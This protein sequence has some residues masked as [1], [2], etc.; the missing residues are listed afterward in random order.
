MNKWEKYS[1]LSIDRPNKINRVPSLHNIEPIIDKLHHQFAKIGKIDAI[2]TKNGHIIHYHTPTYQPGKNLYWDAIYQNAIFQLLGNYTNSD[3]FIAWYLKIPE[4]G[5]I[6][7]ALIVPIDE[8]LSWCENI[9]TDKARRQ[10]KWSLSI[11]E[12]LSTRRYEIKFSKIDPIG[13]TE[14]LNPFDHFLDRIEL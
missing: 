1:M 10:N 14:Y 11:R 8:F 9:R 3:I 4:N 7:A 2:K 6:H 13:V 5:Y 12:Y